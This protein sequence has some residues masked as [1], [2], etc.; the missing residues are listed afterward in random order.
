M[1][2]R[3]LAV[4][5]VTVITILLWSSIY[6][7]YGSNTIMIGKV[8]AQVS[9]ILFL[10]N[11]NMYFVFL[12]IRKSKKRTIKVKFAQISKRL[13]TF[14]IPVA[15]SASLLVFIHI[16]TMIYGK[17]GHLWGQKTI[18]GIVTFSLL[19][20][21]LFSGFLR[22]KKATGKRRRFHYKTAFVFFGLLI[23]HIFI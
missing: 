10:V 20:L 3:W 4:N 15:V 7:G 18:S 16:I 2:A 11:L 8:A 9:F 17:W 13:M 14:H 19:L 12:F 22:K 21:L 6:Q 1:V 5:I 23:L